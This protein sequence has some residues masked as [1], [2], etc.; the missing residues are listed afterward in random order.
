V[1]TFDEVAPRNRLRPG[2]DLTEGVGK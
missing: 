2:F 1:Q